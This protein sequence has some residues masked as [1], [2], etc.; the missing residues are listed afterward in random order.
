VAFKAHLALAD[1]PGSL[2]I[3]D[4]AYPASLV[5]QVIP[6][7]MVSRKV[8]LVVT[9][10]SQDCQDFQVSADILAAVYRAIPAAAYQDTLDTLALVCQAT[11]ENLVT[12]VTAAL[13]ATAAILA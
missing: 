7:L 2:V 6:V 12:L 10:D 13:V 11:L 4:Q 5:S 1:F 8:A 3:A 9:A